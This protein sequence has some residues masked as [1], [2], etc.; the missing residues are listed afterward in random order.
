VLEQQQRFYTRVK[1]NT[2]VVK[3]FGQRLIFTIEAENI[4]TILSQNFDSG[5]NW[6]QSQTRC[7]AARRRD[8][9]RWW[10][11]LAAFSWFAMLEGHVEHPIHAIPR[12]G[13]TVDLQKPF[14]RF[15][16]DVATELLFGESTNDLSPNSNGENVKFIAALNRCLDVMGGHTDWGIFSLLLPNPGFKRDCK[17]VHRQ[18]LSHNQGLSASSLAL[19]CH[20]LYGPCLA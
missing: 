2:V 4:K 12:D 7:S 15:T 20:L 11:P 1:S 8:I 16:L 19:H 10:K 17:L 13:A 6:T 3:I 5:G 18:F 14:P 9:Q